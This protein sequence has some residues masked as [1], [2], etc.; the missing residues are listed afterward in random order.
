MEKEEEEGKQN[1]KFNQSITCVF[2]SLSCFFFLITRSLS[3]MHTQIVYTLDSNQAVSVFRPF[4]RSSMFC[5]LNFSPSWKLTSANNSQHKCTEFTVLV[6]IIFFIFFLDFCFVFN[7]TNINTHSH[8]L[9]HSPIFAHT[10]TK[11]DSQH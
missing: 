9:T 10:H 1:N 7:R 3:T 5:S 2:F 11:F 4:S 6:S 8:S